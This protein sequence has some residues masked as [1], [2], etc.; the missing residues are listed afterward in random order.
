MTC[1]AFSG[2]HGVWSALGSG[3]LATGSRDATV[4]VWRWCGKQRRVIGPFTG[5]QN[6][7]YCMT[8]S[9]SMFMCDYEEL[10]RSQNICFLRVQGALQPLRLF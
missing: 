6:S 3:L 1:I 5:L 2:E 4:L 7:K 8:T 10:I 9:W